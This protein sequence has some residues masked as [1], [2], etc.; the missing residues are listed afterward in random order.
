M[1]AH[2]ALSP[3]LPAGGTKRVTWCGEE[4]RS[5]PPWRPPEGLEGSAPKPGGKA[6]AYRIRSGF[7]VQTAS[8]EPLGAVHGGGVRTRA[9][10]CQEVEGQ[11]WGRPGSKWQTW[12]TGVLPMSTL[13]PAGETGGPPGPL[14]RPT[15]TPDTSEASAATSIHHQPL[16]LEGDAPQKRPLNR[17]DCLCPSV[18]VWPST[19][20]NH[21]SF[22]K[23]RVISGHFGSLLSRPPCPM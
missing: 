17:Q 22:P 9:W 13:C 7:G 12:C 3:P 14:P 5:P 19:D 21:P 18:S 1:G 8:P 23:P 10:L 2:D 4:T 16:S 20:V 6:A 15:P 11:V